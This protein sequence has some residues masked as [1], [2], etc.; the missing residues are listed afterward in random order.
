MPKGKRLLGASWS[1]SS[2]KYGMLI[3]PV[4]GWVSAIRKFFATISSP[5][6][7]CRLAASSS[8]SSAE[9]D[10][11]AIW[12]SAC[13]TCSARRRSATSRASAAVRSCTARSSR[14]MLCRPCSAFETWLAIRANSA[15]SSSL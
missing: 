8:V 4:S 10:R 5:M 1:F 6:M 14:S 9:A 7:R 15:W 13:C 2:T 12:Y 11:S 3:S